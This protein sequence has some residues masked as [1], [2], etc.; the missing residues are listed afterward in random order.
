[1]PCLRAL[2]HPSGCGQ[3]ARGGPQQA[4]CRAIVVVCRVSGFTTLLHMWHF[5]MILIVPYLVFPITSEQLQKG[6]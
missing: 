3:R 1:M 6:T 2:V 4:L 5:V